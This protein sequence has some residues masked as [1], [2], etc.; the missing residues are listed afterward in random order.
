LKCNS[1]FKVYCLF[2]VLF[3]VF[4]E[5]EEY[6]F[7][8][9]I[10]FFM[11]DAINKIVQSII[12]NKN[13]NIEYESEFVYTKTKENKP[14]NF[15]KNSFHRLRTHNLGN[16]IVYI[17]GG[18]KEIIGNSSYSL[19]FVRLHASGFRNNEK[20]IH[21]KIELFAHTQIEKNKDTNQLVFQT[22][23]FTL[24]SNSIDNI[25]TEFMK[26]LE[27]SKD[28]FCFSYEDNTLK[29]G[30]NNS[31]CSNVI[32]TIRRFLEIIFS[33][34]IANE[35]NE[36]D[37]IVLDGNLKQTYTN[38]DKVFK[39]LYSIAKNKNI[40]ILA[41]SKTS[42]LITNKGNSV[43]T[44]LNKIV[45]DYKIDGKWYYYPIIDIFDNTYP[46][47][48]FF[49]KLHEKS[50]FIFKLEIWKNQENIDFEKIFSYIALNSQDPVF[51]GYPYGLID[52]DN[53]ARV[54][55][56][57]T[58]LLNLRI[59]ILSKSIFNNDLENSAHQILDKIKF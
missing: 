20:V 39:N 34:C 9:I 12:N 53:F 28:L 47:K 16:K 29:N 17:D 46:A 22:N 38:E 5:L 55:E 36:F 11:Q 33:K 59:K 23:F 56:Q 50:K 43:I 24:K 40:L 42:N 49:L 14:H 18:N 30:I 7:T 3:K 1:I 58:K 57:E 25:T 37:M 31:T 48:L 52:A 54:T 32:N 35:L 6:I 4:I 10:P 19:Q 2:Y 44:I 21:K 51:L 15:S 13:S 27:F 45:N 41:L 26:E 8:K